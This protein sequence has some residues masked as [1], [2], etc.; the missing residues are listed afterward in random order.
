MAIEPG[1][2]GRPMST[3]IPEAPPRNGHHIDVD[4]LH[5]YYEVTGSGAPLLLL[6]GGLAP[7]ETF[8]PQVPAL[9]EHYAVHVPERA[10]HGRTPDVDGPLTYEA[11][12]QHTISFMEVLD[13]ECAD[14]IGWSDG[15]LVGLLVAL[16][17]PTL[18]RKLVLIDQYVTLEG[19]V[20]E[21]HAFMAT[22][23]ADSAP[24]GLAELYGVLS[25]DGPDHFPVV[26]AKLHDLWTRPTGIE[27]ADLARVA[28]PTLILNGDDGAMSL[29]HADEIRRTLPESQLA[30]VPGTSHGLS[31]EKPH[32]V[33]QLILDFLAD[34]QPPKLFS[35]FAEK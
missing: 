26:F 34:E 35:G 18:V 7:A 2:K 12:A 19:A 1:R 30:V 21:Y 5:T 23:S 6:H 25:P 20:P 28:A 13:I 27:V 8:D 3:T 17:R 15:A 33:N 10:G 22:F 4:G 16:R 29:A 11:M 9:A 24:P 14:L 31:L 32:I